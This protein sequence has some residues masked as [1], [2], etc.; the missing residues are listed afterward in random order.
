M[1]SYPK[2]LQVLKGNILSPA[3]VWLMRQAGRYLPE[4]RA[5]RQKYSDFLQFCLTPDLAVE[6]TLQPLRRYDL[7]AAILFSDILVIPH[8][9]GQR[10][11]FHE[12]KGPQLLPLR[13][14]QDF[15]RLGLDRFLETL[16]PVFETLRRLRVSLSPE[17]AL[18]G[19]AGAP[20]TIF[21][22]MV[23]GGGSR[24]FSQALQLWYR[25]PALARLVMDLICEATE[26]YLVAQV[27]AGAQVL[28]LFDS[29]AGVVPSPLMEQVIYAPTRRLLDFLRQEQPDIPVI[30]FPKG[31]GEKI[32]T[33]VEATGVTALSL[34]TCV[35]LNVLLPQLSPRLPLQGGLDPQVLVAGGQILEQEIRRLEKS[36]A[37][38]PYIFNLGHG[39]VPETPPE[40][41]AQLMRIVRDRG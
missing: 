18:I 15:S 12:G 20:W 34:D 16:S 31:I 29:W 8:A 11:A 25:D 1:E 28:Q 32:P 33:Y 24:T 37:G 26:K 23:E 14:Q 3:P 36:L 27:A 4:Y 21:A 6:A 35:D 13:S 22:Y 30:C 17:K 41:V 5:L 10:V 19:F 40:H 39:V 9:L 7:D 38:R 2:L